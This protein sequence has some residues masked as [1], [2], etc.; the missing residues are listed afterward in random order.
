MYFTHQDYTLFFEDE[1][2]KNSKNKDYFPMAYREHEEYDGV[3]QRSIS[4]YK[5]ISA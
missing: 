2:C 3:Y 4:K 5:Y 1:M